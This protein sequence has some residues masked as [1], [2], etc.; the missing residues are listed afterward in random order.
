MPSVDR[1][2]PPTDWPGLETAG[3]TQ[4]TE[5]LY[6][7]WIEGDANPMFWHRCAALAGV[8]DDRTV[9]GQWVG[10]GTSKHTLISRDPLHL[11]PSLLWRCCDIHGFVR[12]GVWIPA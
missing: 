10:A 11:E 6:Y 12:G 8:P 2:K 4:L 7:G 3:L 1:S 9:H 5:D